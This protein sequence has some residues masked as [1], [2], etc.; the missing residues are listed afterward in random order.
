MIIQSL[1]RYYATDMSENNISTSAW[2]RCRIMGLSNIEFTELTNYIPIPTLE[3]LPD[4]KW[5]LI[6]LCVTP[7]M[8]G[9]V[10]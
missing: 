2:Q 4:D 7:R 1:L 3:R 9:C 6:P 5:W 10:R 8:T